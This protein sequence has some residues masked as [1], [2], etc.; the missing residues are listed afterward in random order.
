MRTYGVYAS[1]WPLGNDTVWTIVNR[2]G[3]EIAGRQMDVPLTPGMRYFD[4]YHGVE[5]KPEIDG[6]DDVLSVSTSKPTATAPFWPRPANPAAQSR[7]SCS[8]WPR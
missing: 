8:A 5:L 4:L 1:R 2:N 3:Y 7:H 6:T